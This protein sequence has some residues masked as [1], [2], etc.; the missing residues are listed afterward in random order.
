M[1]QVA[2]VETDTGGYPVSAIRTDLIIE[3]QSRRKLDRVFLVVDDT[4]SFRANPQVLLVGPVDHVE[5][6][7]TPRRQVQI[8]AA[9]RDPETTPALNLPQDA[10]RERIN[11]VL[12]LRKIGDLFRERLAT[13]FKDVPLPEIVETHAE[14]G[15]RVDLRGLPVLVKSGDRARVEPVVTVEDA[16][17]PAFEKSGHLSPHR[18]R[19]LIFGPRRERRSESP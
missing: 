8:I 2:G 19:L 4:V 3:D 5:L 15:R 17:P 6:P 11:F 10:R 18:N 1:P 7:Q 12:R 14:A 16:P 13:G 9:V